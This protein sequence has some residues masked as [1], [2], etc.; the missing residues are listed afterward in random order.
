MTPL[1]LAIRTANTPLVA[2]LLQGRRHLR[3]A[4]L[5]CALLLLTLCVGWLVGWLVGV[6][7]ADSALRGGAQ[8]HTPL[9]LAAIKGQS[10]VMELLLSRPHTQ[11]DAL[12]G[13]GRSALWL[14]CTSPEASRTARAECVKLLAKHHA[15]LGRATLCTA[16][17][18][19]P[20][21]LCS[22]LLCSAL[23]C[24]ALL[25]SAL[26]CSALLCSLLCCCEG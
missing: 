14:V 15:D 10:D 18:P 11:V 16:P 12:D 20:A 6:A 17:A 25:C 24:S 5:G 22:A 2:R 8:Q 7:G 1:H 26:L 19:A 3:S 23:L 21:L 4:R 13:A 9:H